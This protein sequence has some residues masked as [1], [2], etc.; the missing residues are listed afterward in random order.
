MAQYRIRFVGDGGPSRDPVS[1]GHK[2]KGLFSALKCLARIL[3]TDPRVGVTLG[4]AVQIRLFA[5]D[6]WQWIS[7]ADTARIASDMGIE[8][9]GYPGKSTKNDKIKG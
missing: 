4:T 7:V 1:C 8:L 6:P 3:K 9:I 5:S 2:H